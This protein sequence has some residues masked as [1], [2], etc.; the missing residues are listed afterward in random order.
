VVGGEERLARLDPLC[1]EIGDAVA[2]ELPDMVFGAP[3]DGGITPGTCFVS[4]LLG[5]F[6]AAALI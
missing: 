2:E 5:G 1:T 4:K 6:D 3:E